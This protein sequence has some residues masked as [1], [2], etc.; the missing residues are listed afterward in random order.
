MSRLRT[1]RK[2]WLIGAVVACGLLVEAGAAEAA[3]L[4]VKFGTDVYGLSSNAERSALQGLAF[5]DVPPAALA[6]DMA[7]IKTRSTFHFI[8]QNGFSGSCME[9]AFNG[10]GEATFAVGFYPAPQLGTVAR[11]AHFL[12]PGGSGGQGSCTID[13]PN[14]RFTVRNAAGTVVGTI[15][16]L[17]GPIVYHYRLN[18][19]GLV[20][21]Q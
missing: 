21:L 1:V 9:Q 6:T 20:R 8:A 13:V 4:S 10:N 11:E 12:Y 17:P 14:R 18:S 19:S 5:N 16:M 3:S 7:G 2:W 15:Q